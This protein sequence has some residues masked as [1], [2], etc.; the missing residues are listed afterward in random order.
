MVDRVRITATSGDVRVTAE[1]RDDV[2]VTG[3]ETTGSGSEVVVKGDSDDVDVRV[4]V[5]ID[6]IV[7]NRSGDVT[8]DGS[9]GTVSVTT[10]SG[11]VEAEDVA[12]IDARTLSGKLRVKASRGSVRLKTKSARVRVGRADGALHVAAGS[13]RI[14]IG[15]ARSEVT[16][17]TISGDIEVLLAG[18]APVTAE[19]LSG[20]I[21][22]RV[23][24]E[25]RPQVRLRTTSGKKRIECA[26]G[27]DFVLTARSMSGNIT[28]TGP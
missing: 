22:L 10:S 7:G 16:V 1:P 8:L 15:E 19:T 24:D 18:R 9:L 12:S 14:E 2:V 6:L 27:D 3:G 4:P 28:V 17:K 23:A 21:K 11:D 5:G 25:L 26:T 13:S 20:K